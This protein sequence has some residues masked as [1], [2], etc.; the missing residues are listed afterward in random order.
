MKTI[1]VKATY[2]IEVE[3]ELYPL[4][5]ECLEDG[6]SFV[7]YQSTDQQEEFESELLNA[8]PSQFK[9]NE[10]YLAEHN[11]TEIE[12]LEPQFMNCGRCIK[13]NIWTTDTNKPHP[14][15]GL[16]LGFSF[17]EGLYCDDCLP[18]NRLPQ[19]HPWYSNQ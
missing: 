15:H 17:E 12:V 6:T 16:A 1:L 8:L 2:L 11:S 7:T 19:N 18:K 4:G 9:I 10:K 14:I 5:E 3:D 13:C